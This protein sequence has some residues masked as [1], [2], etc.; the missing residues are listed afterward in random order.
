M[1]EDLVFLQKLQEAGVTDDM[2]ALYRQYVNS[3]DRQ[4]QKRL[5]HRFCRIQNL[6][7]RSD[8]EKITCL[9]YMIAKVENM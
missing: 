9:D 3:G 5:L 7:L 6:K 2:L 8:R 1:I 4:G